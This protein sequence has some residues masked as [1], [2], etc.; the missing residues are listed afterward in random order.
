MNSS[1][2]HTKRYEQKLL[3]VGNTVSKCGKFSILQSI[4]FYVKLFLEVV[5][6]ASSENPKFGFGYLDIT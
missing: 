6:V 4:T 5:I 3:K 2:I 1:E